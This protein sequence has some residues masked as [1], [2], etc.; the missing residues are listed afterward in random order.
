MGSLQRP[1]AGPGQGRAPGGNTVSRESGRHKAGK[2]RVAVRRPAGPS[3]ASRA[4]RR[5]RDSR[6]G[7]REC[8]HRHSVPAG[9]AREEDSRRTR[10]LLPTALLKNYLSKYPEESLCSTAKPPSDRE[11]EG[12]REQPRRPSPC[13]RQQPAGSPAAGGKGFLARR[14]SSWPAGPDRTPFYEEQ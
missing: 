10:A 2:A 4:P 14:P 13:P 3:G 7:A 1:A 11:R 12:S 9:T 5:W 8:P 6:H